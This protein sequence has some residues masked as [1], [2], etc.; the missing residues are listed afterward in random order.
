[1]SMNEPSG[2]NA[3]VALSSV[4]AFPASANVADATPLVFL[5]AATPLNT[6]GVDVIVATPAACAAFAAN[7]AAATCSARTFVLP[8]GTYYYLGTAS[9]LGMAPA[10]SCAA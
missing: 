3:T 4:I 9:A 6:Y 2:A 8:G 10:P 1:M 7:G 5:P